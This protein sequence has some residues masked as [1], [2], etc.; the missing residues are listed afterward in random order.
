MSGIPSKR[1]PKP[2]LQR[3]IESG[4]SLVKISKIYGVH[5][6]T[7]CKWRIHYEIDSVA[8]INKPKDVKCGMATVVALITEEGGLGQYAVPGG[9][10]VTD[11]DEA[12]RVCVAMDYLMNGR[13]SE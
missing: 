6:T 11:R 4:L 8:G 7:V 9:Q 1:P 3:R 12:R 2:E 5:K 13:I 10:I